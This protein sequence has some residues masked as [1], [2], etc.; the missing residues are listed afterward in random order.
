MNRNLY[1]E[2]PVSE[3]CLVSFSLFINSHKPKAQHLAHLYKLQST[4]S[5][6]TM[7]PS[8]QEIR[9]LLEAHIAQDLTEKAA[10]SGKPQQPGYLTNHFHDNVEFHINGHEFPHATQL[11]GAEAIKGELVDGGL[12]EIPNVIDYS[13]P[14][15]SQILQ[16]IGGGPD[17]D[18]AAAVVK[19]T[20]TQH[21]DHLSGKPFNHESVITLQFDNKGKIIHLKNYADTLHIHNILQDI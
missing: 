6:F 16:V 3:A 5:I 4:F 13:K 7:A 17:S 19:A 15:D 1:N 20:A 21:V 14:H 18:W 12:S 11:Q 8:A 9:N 10:N 2:H